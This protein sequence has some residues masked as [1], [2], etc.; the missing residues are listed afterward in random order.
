MKVT[1]YLGLIIRSCKCIQWLSILIQNRIMNLVESCSQLIITTFEW[2]FAVKYL[3]YNF[4]ITSKDIPPKELDNNYIQ[5]CKNFSKTLN[6]IILRIVID[7]LFLILQTS[8]SS[9]IMAS[10]SIRNS[11]L[12]KNLLRTGMF[13]YRV[14]H[15]LY[16]KF[17]HVQYDKILPLSLGS[18]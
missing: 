16:L 7:A 9:L 10:L 11:I 14:R 4:H 6:S 17:L 2:V 1:R 15:S 12:M 18:K 8:I 13:L 3:I 5:E